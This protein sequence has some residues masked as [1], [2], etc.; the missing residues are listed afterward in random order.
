M[1]R[2]EAFE[3]ALENE[4]K[5]GVPKGTH[6]SYLSRYKAGKLKDSTIEELLISAGYKRLVVED[7]ERPGETEKYFDIL[8]FQEG[9]I[10]I[11]TIAAENEDAAAKNI[12]IKN[13]ERGRYANVTGFNSRKLIKS[14]NTFISNYQ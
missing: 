5:T 1:T 13:M 2:N 14:I 8:Y 12:G 11:K 6:S 4:I 7:W 3:K 10:K 9:E